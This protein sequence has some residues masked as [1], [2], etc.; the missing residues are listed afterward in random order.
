MIENELADNKHCEYLL[1]V[2]MMRDTGKNRKS[3]AKHEKTVAA[4]NSTSGID[5]NFI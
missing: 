3:N 4:S 1:K 2:F 5:F